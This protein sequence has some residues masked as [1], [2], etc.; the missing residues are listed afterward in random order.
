MSHKALSLAALLAFSS[1][2]ACLAPVSD[3]GENVNDETVGRGERAIIGGSKATAYPEAVIINMKKGGQ[4]VSACSGAVIAPRVV[5][6]AGHCVHQFDGWDVLAPYASGQKVSASSGATLDWTNTSDTVN[7]SMHDVGLVFLDKAITLAAYP[8]L[9]QAPVAN[10]SQVVNIGRIN[11]GVMSSTNLY[12]SKPITISNASSAGYPYDYMA[13]EVIES[14]DSGGP[15]EIPG[16]HTIVAVNSGAGGG[17]EV[18]A[19]VDLVYSWIQQQIAAHGG[20]GSTGGGSNGGG[21]TA[22]ACAHP[23]C[24]AGVK[25]TASCDPCAQAV[26]AA[27]SYC[28]SSQW[29]AQ[30][31]SEVASICGKSCGG[32]S[33]GSSSGSTSGCGSVTYAGKCSGN[34]VVWCE[35]NA[36]KNLTC[37]G[38]KVCGYDSS[39]GFYN[40]L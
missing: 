20:N 1:L 13:K 32:S 35:N 14:G 26:C 39:Q 5:L 7:P 21:S 6:T 34:A 37:G 16:T 29:D 10:G 38:G 23:V 3:T 17:T 12:V 8:T 9:A 24:T 11:N 25:L 28:C 30:C 15:D 19:R 33:S 36:L 4:V 27:D 22:P 18:L 31:V 2:A 40:C